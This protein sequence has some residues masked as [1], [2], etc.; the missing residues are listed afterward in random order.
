MVGSLKS[1]VA[2]L[3]T[4]NIHKFNEARR[5]FY[6]YS[7]ATLMLKKISVIEV[8]DDDIEKIAE[9]SAKDAVRKID[10]PI[11][12]EDAGLF[13]KALKDFPGPFS[14]HAY[15]TIGNDGILKLMQGLSD[16][17]ARFKSV[18]AFQRPKMNEP[19]CFSGE[20]KGK[21]VK[22]KRGNQ[23][24][25][26]DPIFQPSNSSTTFAEMSLE[27]KNKHSHRASAIREFAEWYSTSP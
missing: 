9:A 17:S 15:R 8:Q 7:I 22:K 18:V 10:L 6:E 25:G 27:E 1:R 13:I 4:S 24:F 12:V 21:I 23:G 26:F 2:F 11:I 3:V 5:V 20:V 16:R 19:L 14:S